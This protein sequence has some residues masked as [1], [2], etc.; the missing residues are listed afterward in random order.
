MQNYRPLQERK[1]FK[2]TMQAQHKLESYL[3]NLFEEPEVPLKDKET[4]ID[5]VAES[6]MTTGMFTKFR[7]D[8]GEDGLFTLTRSGNLQ[9][10]FYQASEWSR[11]GPYV[12]IG[13]AFHNTVID[14]R[15]LWIQLHAAFL[16]IR[17]SSG[18]DAMRKSR[19]SLSTHKS[20]SYTVSLDSEPQQR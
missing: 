15:D 3:L 8:A 14:L 2:D 18:V 20:G 17:A 16:D 12:K 13:N 19:E 7:F 10:A 6:L 1:T 9:S 5:M 11:K 4:F